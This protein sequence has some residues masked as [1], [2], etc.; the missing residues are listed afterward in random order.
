MGQNAFSA[1]ASGTPTG[2]QLA[3][4][5]TAE[6]AAAGLTGSRMHEPLAVHPG[7]VLHDE[8]LAPHGLSANRL[9]TKL[10]VPPQLH[11]CHYQRH[12]RHHRRDVAV[13]GPAFNVAP[14]YFYHLHVRH[15]IE[16]A[17]EEAKQDRSPPTAWSGA[18]ALAQELNLV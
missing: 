15:Q 18:D 14:D 5:V 9:A 16:L 11:H 13:A 3:S 17:M 7:I 8:F 1:A 6:L 10:G 2:T 12:P 4:N